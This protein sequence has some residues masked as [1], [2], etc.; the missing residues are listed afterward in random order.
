MFLIINFFYSLSKT[1]VE[2]TRHYI[3][4]FQDENLWDIVYDFDM[5]ISYGYSQAITEMAYSGHKLIFLDVDIQLSEPS[6]LNDTIKEGNV[7]TCKGYGEYSIIN[8]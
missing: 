3:Q 7:I 5:M 4:I 8:L 6:L 1:I 2:I